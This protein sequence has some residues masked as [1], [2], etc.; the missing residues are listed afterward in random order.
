MISQLV[1]LDLSETR[2]A[3]G[4]ASALAA[5]LITW[6]HA[7]LRVLVLQGADVHSAALLTGGNIEIVYLV[8]SET[9]F[10]TSRVKSCF[11]THFC[12][13]SVDVLEFLRIWRSWH[14]YDQNACI[15]TKF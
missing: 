12:L 15:S 14:H 5:Q 1:A 13:I 3:D 11:Y 7:P 10:Y 2:A 9:A 8:L 6:T 4:G